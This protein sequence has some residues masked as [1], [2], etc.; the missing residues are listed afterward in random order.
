VATRLDA[1]GYRTGLFGKYLNEYSGT[2]IPPGWDRWFVH[3]GFHRYYDYKINAD[4]TVRRFGSSKAAYETDVMANCT[5]TFIGTTARAGKPFFAY[6]APK[7]PHDPATPAPR[8]KHKFDGIRAPHPPPITSKTFPTSPP[9]YDSC[10]GSAVSKG[11][12]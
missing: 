8:D 3:T 1:A 12:R 7:A 9:G 4:G 5:K 6:V 11:R 2:G 10:R